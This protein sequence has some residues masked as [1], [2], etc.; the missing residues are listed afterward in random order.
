MNYSEIRKLAKSNNIYDIDLEIVSCVNSSSWKLSDEEYELICKYV[1]NVWDNVDKT[2]IQLI[3]DI[4]CDLYQDNL[5]YGYRDEEDEKYLTKED[6]INREKLDM[7]IDLFY[8]KYY[9]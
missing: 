9:D 1:W 6:L 4:V 3:S 2:Y 7:V 8:D 5:G